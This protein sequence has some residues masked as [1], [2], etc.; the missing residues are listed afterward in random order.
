M[1]AL[2]LA[3]VSLAAT[4]LSLE[5]GSTHAPDPGYELFSDKNAMGSWGARLGFGL[6]DRTSLLVDWQHSG[7]GGRVTTSADT[8]DFE[9]ALTVDQLAFGPRF[10]IQIEDTV[11]PYVTVQAVGM[12]GRLRLDGDPASDDEIDQWKDSALTGGGL[13][14]GGAQIMLGE[15]EQA[16]RFSGHLEMGY[17]YALPLDYGDYGSISF[18][19]FALRGGAGIVF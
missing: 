14:M 17:G 12:R 10:G 9:A 4:E 3:S 8:A 2:L 13:A 16:V 11:M 1:I 7:P 18:H 5:L 15:P 6:S 19:G